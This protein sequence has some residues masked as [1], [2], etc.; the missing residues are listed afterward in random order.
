MDILDSGMNMH[1]YPMPVLLGLKH[2]GKSSVARSLA[3]FLAARSLD[4]DE[5][6]A[7]EAIGRWPDEFSRDL[8][9]PLIVRQLYSSRGKDCFQELEAFVAR[10]LAGEATDHTRIVATGGGTIENAAA[11]AALQE[12]GTCIFIQV[13]ESVLFA[14]IM[15]G[16]IPPFLDAA[17]PAG[18]FH[19]VYERRSALMEHCAD[20]RVSVRD[21]SL[22]TVVAMVLKAWKE[23]N[24]GR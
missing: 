12:R 10:E 16:G 17:D 7:R 23:Y 11:M 20:I 21:E 24:N 3:P 1:H 2:S 8:H 19:A 18:S 5:L 15:R 13:P 4:M 9:Y 22:E 6:I 14:R